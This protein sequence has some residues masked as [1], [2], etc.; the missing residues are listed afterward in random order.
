MK[1]TVEEAT[2]EVKKIVPTIAMIGD[3]KGLHWDV[4]YLM[5]E[6]MWLAE[7]FID[8]GKIIEVYKQPTTK[9]LIETIVNKK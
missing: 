5:D 3:K 7:F 8:G 6:G 4:G 1:L 9:Q 2:A